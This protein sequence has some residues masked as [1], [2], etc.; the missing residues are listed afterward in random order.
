MKYRLIHLAFIGA[1]TC[2]ASTAAHARMLYRLCGPL[3]VQICKYTA[4]V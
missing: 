2:F 3:V 4:P 1:A